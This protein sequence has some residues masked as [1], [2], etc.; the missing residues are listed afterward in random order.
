LNSEGAR[1]VEQDT[2]VCGQERVDA[3]LRDAVAATMA[4]MLGR[5]LEYEGPITPDTLLQNQLGLSSSLAL[6]VLLGIEEE[7]SIQIDVEQMDEDKIM[8]LM[9]LATYIAGHSLPL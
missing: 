4:A 6:E 7:H 2:D 9:D 1:A 5:L 8:T 3:E